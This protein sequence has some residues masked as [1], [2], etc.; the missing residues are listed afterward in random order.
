MIAGHR[1][2]VRRPHCIQH[3]PKAKWKPK[4]SGQPKTQVIK[5]SRLRVFPR[6]SIGKAKGL[7]PKKSDDDDPEDE[8]PPSKP[9]EPDRKVQMSN[10]C[11]F[12]DEDGNRCPRPP[13]DYCRS[14]DAE[15]RRHNC[16][17]L[18]C[19]H[20]FQKCAQCVKSF[21]VD[22]IE[23]HVGSC[24]RFVLATERSYRY[25]PPSSDAAVQEP[26]C[27]E[28]SRSSSSTT[29]TPAQVGAVVAA[30]ASRASPSAT[31]T[32]AQASGRGRKRKRS[33]GGNGGGS[34][35]G[36]SFKGGGQGK[37]RGVAWGGKG[38]G[39][40]D[41]EEKM[42]DGRF[43]RGRNGRE[44]CWAWNEG[45][46]PAEQGCPRMHICEFCR[47]KGHMTSAC[48]DKPAGWTP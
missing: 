48:P 26:E 21:C 31:P 41:H 2:G 1:T 33:D 44:I 25:P 36:G 24:D 9:E 5:P 32:P 16:V 10:V 27:T 35:G 47:T 14:R 18:C 17:N 11:F 38:A 46:C 6:G 28:P 12:K 13:A 20:H 22:C 19:R 23:R 37:G 3:G 43:K 15:T 42:P 45:N 4:R 7:L 29:P 39:K 40:G 30:A 34:N 8:E